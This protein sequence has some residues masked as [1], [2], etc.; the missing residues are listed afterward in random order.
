VPDPGIVSATRTAVVIGGASGIGRATVASFLASGWVV[1]VGDLNLASCQ[2]L[3]E[4]FSAET[5]AGQLHALQVDVSSESDVAAVVDRAVVVSG[6]LDAMVNSAGIGGAF[7]PVTELT[8]E[9]W[10]RTFSVI[11]RGAF[12]TTKHAARVMKTQPDGGS[13]V[14]VAS[15]AALTGDAGPQAYSVAKAAVLHMGKVFASELGPDRIRVNTVCPGAIATPLNPAASGQF[16]GTDLQRM[17]PLPFVG[18]P[19]HVAAVILF[20]SSADAAFVTGQHIS[21]DGGLEAAGPRIGEYL[22]SNPRT[23]SVVGMNHGNTGVRSFV[24]SKA[25]S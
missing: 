22:G 3:T 7:G 8:V 23:V 11:T 25:G 2:G 13:I 17:Q 14:N 21:A 12:L 16:E 5:M 18:Q 1:V 9:D 15:L 24:R 10:D 6:R 4:E 19:Q 20:L